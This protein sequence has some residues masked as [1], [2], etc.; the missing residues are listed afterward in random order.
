LPPDQCVVFEDAADGVVAAQAA[1]MPTVGIGPVE[2]VG[3]ADV[4]LPQGLA[5]G[6]LESILAALREQRQTAA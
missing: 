3:A 5:D 1:G 6:D 2:R 4:V